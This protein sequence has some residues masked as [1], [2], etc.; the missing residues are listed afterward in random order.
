[1]GINGEVYEFSK[2]INMKKVKSLI[3][4]GILLSF[5]GNYGCDSME[6][7]FKQYL[8]EYNYSGKIDRLRVYP[9]FERVILAWDNP[10]DQKSKSIKI[11]YGA[12]STA[13]SYDTLVDSVSI[14]GL[15]A[16]TGYEFIVYTL[17]ANKNISVP[18]SITA[19]P[20]SQAFVNALTPPS[21]VAQVIGADQFISVIGTSNVLMRFAGDIEYTVTGSGGFTQSGK[22][23]LPDMEGRPQINLP[24]AAMGIPFLPPGEYKFDYKVSVLP[25]VGNLPSVDEVWLT[26]SQTVTVQPVVINLMTTPGKV[27]ESNNNS[28]GH[29][30]ENVDK[31]I[32]NDPNTKYLTFQ[33]T[34]WMMWKMDRAFAATRYAL[35]SGND[36]DGRDPKDWTIEASNDGVNWTV[37]DRQTNFPK[38]PQRK[39][40][41]SFLMPNRTA[42]SY[43]RLNVTANHGSGLFQLADWILYYDS[44]QQ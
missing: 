5:L 37:I 32:D 35:T 16:G 44:G 20:V 3:I 27:T 4:A 25:I 38:F 7:N 9:G 42:Y 36:D 15:N 12:D 17:D 30:G 10:K 13:V 33:S 22:Y 39:H 34:A 28:P 40:R 19:F 24:V 41:I 6:D 21:L 1:M 26:N 14:E 2:M 29:G 8:E 31:L 43:Y 11:I 18:T 23:Q